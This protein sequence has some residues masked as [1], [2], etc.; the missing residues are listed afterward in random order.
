M[1][2]TPLARDIGGRIRELREALGETQ[3]VFAKRFT[4]KLKQVSAWENGRANPSRGMLQE[5][6]SR[7]GWP[8]EMFLEGGPRPRA[9]LSSP[10][11]ERSRVR[12]TRR[13][14]YGT[15]GHTAFLEAMRDLSGYAERGDLVPPAAAIQYV[16]TVWNLCQ[17]VTAPARDEV[18]GILQAH[19]GTGGTDQGQA[20]PASGSPLPPPAKD[21]TA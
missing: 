12:E 2:E 10:A 11:A 19:A 15:P 17:S 1:A 13:V 6:A 5:V 8:F 21:R 20:P 14:P 7:N 4:R 9:A 3:P 16:A 18:S